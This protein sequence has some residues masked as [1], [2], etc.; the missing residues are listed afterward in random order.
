MLRSNLGLAA[1]L[2]FATSGAQAVTITVDTFSYSDYTTKTAGNN[3]VIEDFEDPTTLTDLGNLGNTTL[4][5][6]LAGDLDSS[7]VG[8]FSSQGGTGSGSTCSTNNAAAG[9]S[10]RNC[11]TLARTQGTVNG[12][13]NLVPNNG[14]WSLNSNDTTGIRWDAE[15]DGGVAF[16]E[17]VFAM[18]DPADTGAEVQISVDGTAYD[19]DIVRQ[20]NGQSFLVQIVFSQA[21]TFAQIDILN[22]NGKVNDAISFDGAAINAVPI[23][24]AAWLFGSALVGMVGIGHRRRSRQA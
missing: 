11:T 19:A 3:W 14:N 21:V 15:L 2:A 1:A 6:T 7:L 16:T 9:V 23:P 12:Q 5:G 22:L 20:R 4:K 17:I 18:Q 24:A 8:Q 10:G 13:G